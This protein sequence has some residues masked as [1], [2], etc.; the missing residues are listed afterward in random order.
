[1][2]NNPRQL[3]MFGDAAATDSKDAAPPLNTIRELRA[4]F[5]RARG[6][7]LGRIESAVDA[8]GL[9]QALGRMRERM[10]ALEI[11]LDD[12]SRASGSLIRNRAAMVR[13]EVETVQAVASVLSD[14]LSPADL[15]R[16]R[17]A[18]VAAGL[19]GVARA[20][21]DPADLTAAMQWTDDDD[22]DE[23][24][25]LV[26]GLIH[27]WSDDGIDNDPDLDGIDVEAD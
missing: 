4:D 20:M 18:L 16:A 5:D 10:V 24:N 3:T 6:I 21:A 27:G 17:R 11:Q 25:A 15:D 19:A 2:S 12:V 14:L 9:Y 23:T 22:G 1:M 8:V 26:A 13:S 7:A